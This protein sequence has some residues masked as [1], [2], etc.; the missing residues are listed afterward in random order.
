MRTAHDYQHLSS[1]P[2]SSLRQPISPRGYATTSSHGPRLPWASSTSMQTWTI[3]KSS[4]ISGPARRHGTRRRARSDCLSRMRSLLR[5][6]PSSPTPKCT[7]P[8]HSLCAHGRRGGAGKSSATGGTGTSY[9][10]S[11]SR[12]GL[13]HRTPGLALGAGTPPR[14]RSALRETS[15]RCRTRSTP[16]SAT[17]PPPPDAGCTGSCRS[18]GRS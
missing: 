18:T 4:S 10:S 17:S 6:L 2:R 7:P 11:N 3:C 12:S 14:T 16:P 8:L 15:P 1:L 5:P 13:H 9:P